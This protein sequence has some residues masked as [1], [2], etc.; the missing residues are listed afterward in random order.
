MGGGMMCGMM[1]RAAAHDD[2]MAYKPAVQ[3]QR[4]GMMCPCCRNM[5]MM[6]PQQPTQPQQPQQQP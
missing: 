3:P 4:Q 6:R 1:G 5:G 2:P